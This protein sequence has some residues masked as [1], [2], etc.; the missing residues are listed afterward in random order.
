MWQ[1]STYWRFVCVCVCVETVSTQRQW[2]DILCEDGQEADWWD[3]WE[4][5][6]HWLD[7]GADWLIQVHTHTKTHTFLYIYIYIYTYIYI[8]LS[9][10]SLLCMVL[11]L[12][13]F[14]E[15]ECSIQIIS[16]SPNTYLSIY[17]NIWIK[18]IYGLHSDVAYLL[19]FIYCL[20]RPFDLCYLTCNH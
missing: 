1:N 12:I 18:N 3:C 11:V 5:Y 19:R 10:I 14:S 13:T 9:L 4:F 17:F 6:H 16:I 20:C 2:T 7:W 15:R 8:K